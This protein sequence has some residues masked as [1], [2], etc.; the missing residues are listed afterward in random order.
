MKT[1]NFKG[2]KTTI[3][4]ILILLTALASVLCKEVSW[5]EAIIGIGAGIGLILAKD[6]TVIK[7]KRTTRNMKF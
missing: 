3:F 7:R 5:H 1:Q 6:N 4:G 2:L